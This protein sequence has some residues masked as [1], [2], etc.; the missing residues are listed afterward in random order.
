M[1]DKQ[2]QEW[3]KADAKRL[4]CDYKDACRRLQARLRCAN[5]GSIWECRCTLEQ[6][7]AAQRRIAA[8]QRADYARRVRESHERIAAAQAAW[9]KKFGGGIGAVFGAAG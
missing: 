2:Y 8:R 7:Y 1:T 6:M 4:Y 5:C 9:D 3:C